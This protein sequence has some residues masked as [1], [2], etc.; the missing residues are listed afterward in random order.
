MREA[1]SALTTRGRAFLAAG[2]TIAIC[3][4]ILGFDALLRVG[5]LALALPLLTALA[6]SR[7]RYRLMA[8]RRVAPTR[9]S[10]GQPATVT[11]DLA[12]D[13]SMPMGLLLL[14]DTVPYVLG[15]RA[16]FLL[17]HAG[18]RW[19][20]SVS[21]AVRSEL[22]GRYEI[23]PL[24]IR[25]SDPFGLFELVRSFQ[26]TTSVVV[27]PQI[28]PLAPINVSGEWTG[29]GENRPRAFAVGSAEDVTVRE[30]R[31]GDDLRRVHWRSSARVG[32]LMVRREE[33]PWQ[34]R[35]TI[36]LDS[37]AMAHRGSGPA[38]S[39]EWA[40][41]AAAS[42]AVHLASAGFAVRLV[43]DRPDID[44]HAWHDR[45]MNAVGQA[46]PILDELAVMTDSRC[47]TLSEAV[48]AVVGSPGLVV[49]LLGRV[50]GTDLADLARM[51]PYRS[52]VLGI[53][54]D[55]DRWAPPPRQSRAPG[56]TSGLLPASGSHSSGVA[57][58]LGSH[59]WFATSAGPEDSVTAVWQRLGALMNHGS[60]AR[61]AVTATGMQQ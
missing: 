32:E 22:R 50:Q 6:V 16:R 40:I 14:E 30:Y 54:L 55:T 15:T 7:A 3:A 27:I 51:S 25:V 57:A 28:Y 37:R 20:Q 42:I 60:G 45:S 44:A 4:F 35:A 39:L 18:P 11:L 61:G 24:S 48:D 8:K 38:S 2:L 56:R 58:M 23:G 47:S 13:G 46:G 53:V 10:A 49:A 33:Q 12:N 26:N 34:S 36:L 29:A 19:H 59:G 17:D 43:T 9:V 21:Y 52:K 5:V 1:L 41:S 31:R